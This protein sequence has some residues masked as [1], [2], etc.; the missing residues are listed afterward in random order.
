VDV[1]READLIEEVGRHYGFDRLP[2]TFPA[3]QEPQPPPAPALARD[4]VIRQV[5]T[6]AGFSES[7][8]FAFIERQAAV[9]FCEG[10]SEPAMIANPLS[11]K[12]AALRPSLLPGLVDSCVHNR[13]RERKD[14]RLFESGSRFTP[15]GEGRAV[16]F[17]WCGAASGPHWS[18]PTRTVDFFDAKGVVELVAR[19]L[20]LAV[21][22]V[23]AGRPYMAP[24]RTAEIVAVIDG[25]RTA[26][27][28]VGQIAPAV[29]D[30]RGFPPSEELYA[31]ELD[32]TALRDAAP[33]PLT[34][35]SLPRYPS[36]V[37]DV[38]ILVDE[39][40]PAA[41]VRG[42]I[43]AAAPPTL[44]SI[45]EF[46]RYQGKGVPEG[47]VSLSVRLTFRA[48]ERTLTDEEADAATASI[49][50]ALKAAHGA[51]RR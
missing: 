38:S 32:V 17:A 34:V 6:A 14:V 33:P 46:D 22:F 15:D 16:A 29:A 19:A 2:V 49:V 9:P 39:A 20:Q 18:Q 42:T 48:P 5:L 26:I 30:A 47:R 43:R 37:R 8:T 11:E 10:G 1:A 41:T 24:G 40:L 27:G 12:F 3:L 36:I 35:E 23:P 25:A 50:D 45:V 28:V 31:A 51:E 44:T 7:M 13:R 21:E 4:R